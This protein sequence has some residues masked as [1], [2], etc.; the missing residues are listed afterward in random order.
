MSQKMLQRLVGLGFN[1]WG[2]VSPGTAAHG[3]YQLFGRPPKPDLRPKE[4][5]FLE[6][7]RLERS[8]IAG[9]P[10]VEYHWGPETGKIVLLCYGW[11]YNAGR[12]RH[13]VP[14]LLKAGFR[15]IAYDPPGHGLN[16]GRFC[17]VILNSDI[18]AGLIEKYGRPEAALAHSFGGASLVRTLSRLAPE[19][20]P[21]RVVIM[22]AF[23]HVARL[24]EA[25]RDAI[26]LWPGVYNNLI[27]E[28][29][30]IVGKPLA[31]FDFARLSRDFG[32]VKALLVH[33]PGDDVTP[34]SNALSYHEHWPGSRL[35]R[36]HG[37]GHHLGLAGLTKTIL[38][39][40]VNGGA[41][42]GVE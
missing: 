21:D 17:N 35:L 15:V 1:L 3:A 24:F 40:L 34:F 9:Y 30:G 25:Y 4:L 37:G 6:T 36:A 39:F 41:V 27:K 18:Q 13:Y 42:S 7:A 23:S 29:E 32:A 16:P 22:A 31:D 5:R 12:W 33:D 10:V 11:R 8:T 2:L 20:R 19:M 28:V 14:E 26:G 38:G